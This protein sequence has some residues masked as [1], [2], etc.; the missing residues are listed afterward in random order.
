MGYMHAAFTE[1]FKVVVQLHCCGIGCKC[2]GARVFRKCSETLS[3]VLLLREK[4]FQGA[5]NWCDVTVSFYIVSVPD[6]K[7]N[8]WSLLAFSTCRIPVQ[9][10]CCIEVSIR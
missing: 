7:C 8:V 2:L 4:L 3:R 10:S 6:E 5:V 1:H 9:A